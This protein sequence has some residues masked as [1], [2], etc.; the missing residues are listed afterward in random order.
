VQYV[1]GLKEKILDKICLYCTVIYDNACDSRNVFANIWR[2]E[3]RDL[4]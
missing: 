1:V 3:P 4:S 2:F